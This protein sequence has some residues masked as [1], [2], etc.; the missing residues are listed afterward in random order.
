MCVYVCVIYLLL[1]F[2][3]LTIENEPVVRDVIMNDSHE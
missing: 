2:R 1:F 3:R